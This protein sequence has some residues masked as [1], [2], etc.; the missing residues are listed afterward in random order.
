[1]EDMHSLEH[2]QHIDLHPV[3]NHNAVDHMRASLQDSFQDMMMEVVDI[4]VH[5]KD[6][7]H[8]HSQDMLVPRQEEDMMNKVLDM[9]WKGM[10]QQMVEIVMM[11][12]RRQAEYKKEFERWYPI[13]EEEKDWHML[14]EH[15]VDGKLNQRHEVVVY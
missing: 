14:L 5:H 2:T 13:Q 7:H 10:V 8:T 4:V 12:N 15:R 6:L 11:D 3:L 1:M 9:G